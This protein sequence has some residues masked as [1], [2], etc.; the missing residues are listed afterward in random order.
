[1]NERRREGKEFL[2]HLHLSNNNYLFIEKR[3]RKRRKEIITR[4]SYCLFVYLK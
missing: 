3:R 1:M 4:I 2:L